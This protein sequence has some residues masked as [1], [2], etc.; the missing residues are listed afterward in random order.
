MAIDTGAAVSIVSDA[1]YHKTL[2]HVYLK[3]SKIV[4]KTYTG[5]PVTV[6]GV[7]DVEV[8]LN[9]QSATL[10]LYLVKGKYPALLG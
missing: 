2:K 9:G 5:E 3:P 1:V 10:P 6:K 4:L 7:M 8:E